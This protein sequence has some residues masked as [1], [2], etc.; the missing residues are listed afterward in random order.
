LITA[1]VYGLQFGHGSDAV[2]DA[3]IRAHAVGGYTSR[4]TN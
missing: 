4:A 1:V 3:S 2:E